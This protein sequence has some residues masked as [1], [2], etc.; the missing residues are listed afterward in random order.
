MFPWERDFTDED[1][2]G[3]D[4]KECVR[5][6]MCGWVCV[7]VCVCVCGWVCVCVCVWVSVCVCASVYLCICV[8]VCV[9]RNVE[10]ETEKFLICRKKFKTLISD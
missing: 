2:A 9:C 3:G 7:C 4:D 10:N 5:V 1:E 8:Y 6:C